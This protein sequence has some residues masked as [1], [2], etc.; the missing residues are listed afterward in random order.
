MEKR[1]SFFNGKIKQLLYYKC[2][3]LIICKNNLLENN[4]IVSVYPPPKT[5]LKKIKAMSKK[6][7]EI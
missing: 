5:L 7:K 4:P 2:Q 6:Y 3:E 1:I